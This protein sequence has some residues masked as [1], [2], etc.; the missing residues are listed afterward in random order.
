MRLLHCFRLYRVCFNLS[1]VF[2]IIA[3]TKYLFGR[4]Q[5]GCS[6]AESSVFPVGAAND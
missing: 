4:L 6:P 1:G 5:L 3:C 2:G